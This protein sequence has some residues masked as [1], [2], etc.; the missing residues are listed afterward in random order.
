MFREELRVVANL[1]GAS[2]ISWLAHIKNSLSSMGMGNLWASPEDSC[3]LIPRKVLKKN[4]K[5]YNLTILLGGSR[6]GTFTTSFL[7]V[8]LQYSLELVIDDI[9]LSLA[10]KLYLQFRHVTLPMR[11]LTHKWG[12]DSTKDC[13]TCN[14]C[15]ETDLHVLFFC[16]AYKVARHR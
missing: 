4:Y 10:K 12:S 13:P 9:Q 3:L 16:P 7:E 6:I 14:N 11:A 15:T 5:E 1:N 2:K 8:K